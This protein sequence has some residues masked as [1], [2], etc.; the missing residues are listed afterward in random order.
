MRASNTLGLIPALSLI[1]A[2][3]LSACGT[4]PEQSAGTDNTTPATSAQNKQTQTQQIDREANPESAYT[5]V[6]STVLFAEKTASVSLRASF[7]TQDPGMKQGYQLQ[8]RTLSD[9]PVF[10]SSISVIAGGQR[11]FVEEGQIVLPQKKGISLSLSLEESLFIGEYET[12]LLQFR[13]NN[14]SFLMQIRLHQLSEFIP[15]Q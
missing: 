5:Y 6:D 1:V 8:F 13:Y 7:G 10:L 11:L 4:T 2:A 9:T 15:A 14:E 3:V 12:A